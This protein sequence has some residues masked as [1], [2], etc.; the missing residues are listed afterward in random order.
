MLITFVVAFWNIWQLATELK[1]SKDFP[2]LFAGIAIL[3]YI[4]SVP[5]P[6]T[7]RAFS[8][9]SFLGHRYPKIAKEATQLALELQVFKKILANSKPCLPSESNQ[10]KRIRGACT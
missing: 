3:G 8:L 7:M 9:L 1:G 4:A 6:I 2:K 5:E 10:L